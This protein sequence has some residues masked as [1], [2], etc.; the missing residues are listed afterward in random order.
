[1]GRVVSVGPR[2]RYR[3]VLGDLTDQ[4]DAQDT[5]YAQELIKEGVAD[6]LMR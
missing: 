2:F 4:S 6:R 3:W 5:E 1:M